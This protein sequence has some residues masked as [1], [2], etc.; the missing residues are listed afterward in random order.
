MVD[1]II[2]IVVSIIM[3]ASVVDLLKK[4]IRMNF[5]GVSKDID[6]QGVKK[7][8]LGIPGISDVHHLHVWSLSTTENAMTAHMVTE[9]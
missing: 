9:K 6:I 1:P 4:S 3:I 5:D 8:L 7:E 2:S